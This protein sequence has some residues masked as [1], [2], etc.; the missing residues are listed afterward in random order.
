MLRGGGAQYFLILKTLYEIKHKSRE[1]KEMKKVNVGVW[2]IFLILFALNIAVGQDWQTIGSPVQ[3]TFNSAN[4]VEPA[5]SPDGGMIAFASDR[6]GNQEIYI[7][8][9]TTSTEASVT[10]N[11]NRNWHPDW[12]QNGQ[13]I[14][15]TGGPNSDQIWVSAPDG[16][17]T[18]AI[19]TSGPHRHPDWSPDGS[20]FV[21]TAQ[22]GIVGP[23]QRINSDGSGTPITVVSSGWYA[24]WAPDGQRIVFSGY[25][26]AGQIYLVDPDG[27][28]LKNISTSGDYHSQPAWSPDGSVIACTIVKAGNSEIYILDTLGNELL[29][30]TN[31]PSSDEGSPTWSPLLDA[32]AFDSNRSGNT[33]IWM[34]GI[35]LYC[36]CGDVNCDG[37]VNILD[38]VYLINYKYK[39]GTAPDPINRADVNCDDEIDILDIIYLSNYKYKDGPDP[40]PCSL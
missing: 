6:T 9:L 11:G 3:L 30:L 24:D 38:I 20:E 37:L 18:I 12:L 40:C 28:N 13:L 32:I 5:W 33:D 23:I 8:N 16:S 21:F 25:G 39:E 27:G 4:D 1:D 26:G 2:I 35:K 34:I 22:I 7:V 36:P 31:I 19:T 17:G 15:Y 29:Q 14:S 10:N